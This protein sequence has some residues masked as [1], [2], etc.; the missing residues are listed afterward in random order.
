MKSRCDIV[1]FVKEAETND[2][3]KYSLRTLDNWPY[4]YVWFCGGCPT[5]LRPDKRFKITQ[6]G[7]NKWEIV[8]NNIRLA[9]ENEEISENFW[10]FNDDFFI[11]KPFTTDVPQ[12][13]GELI[14]Y[15]ESII[16]KNNGS[17]SQYTLRLRGTIEALEKIGC[18]TLNY[19]VH[20]PMLINKQMGLEI[21]NRFPNVPGFR[22]LY[23]NYYQIGGINRRDMKI[24]LLIYNM[25]A[26]DKN[27]DFLST[28]DDSFKNGDAGRYIRDKFEER[29][30]FEV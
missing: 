15:I 11:L 10:L 21:L 14:D 27:W 20:K 12:Y 7:L 5:G 6:K 23:G 8:R 3:L 28:S 18:T 22:S 29:S 1:Y 30:R 24:R 9:L 25:E 16:K 13:D 17:E 4:R 26:V 2:E 19:E